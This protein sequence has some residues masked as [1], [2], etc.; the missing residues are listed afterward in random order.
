MRNYLLGGIAIASALAFMVQSAPASAQPGCGVGHPCSSYRAAG[1]GPTQYRHQRHGYAHG[2][3][4]G[5]G[6]GVGAAALA[7]GV[8]I[9]GVMQQNQGYYYPAETYP[10][11]SYPVYSDQSPTYD[12]V[13]P[14]VVNDGDSTAYCQ[15]T[16]RSY[17]T[18][19][20]TYLG[21]DGLRHPCP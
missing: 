16:Y 21:Y 7:T 10:A 9:G 14:Q 17:D 1:A 8:I 2:Y 13:G 4:Q 11:E 19:S 5:Y 18:V 6:I 20:G 12:V 15:Q 3:G